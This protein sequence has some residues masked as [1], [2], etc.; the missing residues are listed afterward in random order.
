MTTHPSHATLR[1]HAPHAGEARVHGGL[2]R[3]YGIGRTPAP[4]RTPR[5]TA[6]LS[7]AVRGVAD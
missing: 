7:L 2:A 4:A 5:V 6:V 3:V 1:A